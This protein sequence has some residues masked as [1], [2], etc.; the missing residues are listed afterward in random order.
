MFGIKC[1]VYLQK[2]GLKGKQ[3]YDLHQ[4]LFFQVE[5]NYTELELKRKFEDCYQGDDS[6]LR[7]NVFYVEEAKFL[8]EG[9]AT[10]YTVSIYLKTKENIKI[11]KL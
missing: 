7:V 6:L 4:T 3:T 10:Q 8:Y 11:P 2:S 1:F 5:K 9:K